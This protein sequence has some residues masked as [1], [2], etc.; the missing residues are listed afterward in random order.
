MAVGAAALTAW[1]VFLDPQM[2]A[3]DYWRWTRR[4]SYRGIPLVNYAGWL[5]A[6]AGVMALLEA[7]LPPGRPDRVL[8]AEYAGMG[9]METIGFAAFFR[10]RLVAIAGALAMVP[11]SAAAVWGAR[12]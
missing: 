12:G 3:E 4:G 10:D 5:V 8:V 1:D 11:L 6:G 2:T 7:L 9:V